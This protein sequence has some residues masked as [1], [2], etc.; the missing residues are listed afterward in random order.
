MGKMCRKCLKKYGDAQGV[1]LF[2]GTELSP[3]EECRD[4]C[5]EEGITPEEEALDKAD[6]RT[7]IFVLVVIALIVAI[8]FLVFSVGSDF[9][10]GGVQKVLMQDGKVGR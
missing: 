3:E 8:L 1:C 9:W 6:I 4:I 7:L 2:C 10:S 5:E